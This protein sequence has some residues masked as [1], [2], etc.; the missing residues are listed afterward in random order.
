MLSVIARIM[1]NNR[2]IGYRLIDTESKQTKDIS[3]MNI[4]KAIMSGLTITGLGVEKGRLIGTNGSLARYAA[5]SINNTLMNKP[6]LVVLYRVD[7][8]F[9]CSD[10][11]G[12]TG[13]YTED[14]VV[15]YSKTYGIANGKIVNNN[16]KEYV[17]SIS[18][19]Y[20]RL[21]DRDKRED[22]IG[23]RDTTIDCRT[24]ENKTGEML[25]KKGIE[26]AGDLDYEA[27][28]GI[29]DTIYAEE[30]GI[31]WFIEN[32]NT[33]LVKIGVTILKDGY[34]FV[35]H[36]NNHKRI[37][38]RKASLTFGSCTASV[39]YRNGIVNKCF[40][41]TKEINNIIGS[42]RECYSNLDW[43]NYEK[44][45]GIESDGFATDRM[46]LPIESA[47]SAF[48][49]VP[50]T[51][52]KLVNALEIVINKVD[53]C[54]YLALSEHGKDMDRRERRFRLI[55]KFK[56]LD[57]GMRYN[58]EILQK[59][60]RE[61]LE[62][63]DMFKLSSKYLENEKGPY[64]Y[65]VNCYRNKLSINEELYIRYYGATTKE[66]GIVHPAECRPIIKDAVQ[67]NGFMRPVYKI[68]DYAFICKDMRKDEYTTCNVGYLG[69]LRAKN[70][71]LCYVEEDM[72]NILNEMQLK[73]MQHV[74]PQ[75]DQGL[76]MMAL[77][78]AGG[79]SMELYRSATSNIN[80]YIMR[81][82]RDKKITLFGISVME[83]DTIIID[84]M[85]VN[86]KS[87][88]KF[89]EYYL[90]INK[91]IIWGRSVGNKNFTYNVKLKAINRNW[92][93]DM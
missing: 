45:V 52:K 18:G 50:L 4:C 71:L 56:D 29:M 54:C 80:E 24:K 5:V 9:I 92:E 31:D 36:Y 93:Q 79:D 14:D 28:I 22:N 15:A 77:E 6:S 68:S 42:L 55:L 39:L 82:I 75:G 67:G 89:C 27:F 63:A 11:K 49:Y 38:A 40:V 76:L 46:I 30:I 26:V 33:S 1:K 70:L 84:G 47:N 61:S 60:F 74:A 65:L 90:Y 2:N 13:R 58:K 64:S 3:A 32:R 72:G 91:G 66:L 48:W 37:R 16:N 25:Y 19:E 73:R 20:T 41:H 21:N 81:Y 88:V 23:C 10:F 85:A 51:N 87:G 62:R 69:E 59:K 44:S 34:D 57:Y 7:G 53:G 43:S 17:S 78:V 83:D 35:I 12:K 8:G 86:N